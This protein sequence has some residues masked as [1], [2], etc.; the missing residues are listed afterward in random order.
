MAKWGSAKTRKPKSAAVIA[1]FVQLDRRPYQQRAEREIGAADVLYEVFVVVTEG[2]D[3]AEAATGEVVVPGMR[4]EQ[5]L[6]AGLQGGE[7][8]GSGAVRATIQESNFWR[9]GGTWAMTAAPRDG[10]GSTLT[11][12]RER[13]AKNAKARTPGVDDAAHGSAGSGQGTAQGSCD[14]RSAIT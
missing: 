6:R 9:P 8:N 10:G 1:F 11:V 12:T 3:P 7:W 2:R 13:R 4:R 14:L 5:G